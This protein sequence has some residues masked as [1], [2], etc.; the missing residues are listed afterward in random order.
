MSLRGPIIII[1][2]DEDDREMIGAMLDEL[3]LPNAIRY[4]E[5]GSPALDYLLTTTESPLLILSDINMPMMNGLELRNNIDA[6]PYLRRKSIPFIFLTTSDSH[7]L[8][9]E[10]YNGTIQGYFKKCNN[11]EEGKTHLD[12]II[13]Y[14]RLC[15]HPNNFK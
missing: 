3:G 4:F 14:W 1:D 12:L 7:T 5:N 15:L 2:D 13:T 9:L 11:F 8:V 6:N 10:A